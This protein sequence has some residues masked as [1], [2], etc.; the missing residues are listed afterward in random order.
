MVVDHCLDYSGPVACNVMH[1]SPI[2]SRPLRL[3]GHDFFDGRSYSTTRSQKEHSFFW[4]DFLPLLDGRPLVEH[5][6]A[7]AFDQFHWK[8][9]W[10]QTSGARPLLWCSDFLLLDLRP[11]YS[12]ITRRPVDHHTTFT[13]LKPCTAWFSLLL[14]DENAASD[15]LPATFLIVERKPR[16]GGRREHQ[17]R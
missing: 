13:T 17:V 3:H 16:R 6:Q 7:G 15:R 12:S 5:S 14:V 1:C 11:F 10:S 9:Q 2:S 8:V 4:K